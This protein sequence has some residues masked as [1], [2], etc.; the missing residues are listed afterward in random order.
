MTKPKKT[1]AKV[2]ALNVWS[3]FGQVW[4]N[5]NFLQSVLYPEKDQAAGRTWTFWFVYNSLIA[6]V[7][8][9]GLIVWGHDFAK[10]FEADVKNEVP[11]FTMSVIDGKFSTDLPQPYVINALEEDDI[12]LAID[13]E[14]VTY[15]RES[16]KEYEGG[17][18]IT[19]DEF[20]G[21]KSSGQYESFPFSDFE[22][23]V[24]FTRAD[25]I[26]G[27]EELKPRILMFI[28]GF[29]FVAIWFWLCISRLATAAWWALVFW[30]VG[31]ALRIPDWNFGKSYLSVLNFYIIPLV[32]E[33]MLLILGVGLFPFSTLL[34]FGLV[35]G[36]NFYTFKKTL[37]AA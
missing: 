5:A 13:T 24:T 30:G 26:N 23:D 9:V 6:L 22:E 21:K 36:V 15:S 3:R 19:A 1:S 8:S 16:L 12:L 27:W 37:N 31:A 2:P 28:Y 25:L 10:E 7:L 33:L 34:V 14:E 17:L 29:I 35:F 18:V 32:F 4:T 11:E 20:I